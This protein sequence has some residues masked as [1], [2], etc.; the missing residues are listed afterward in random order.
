MIFEE[1]MKD[2]R[3]NIVKIS[4]KELADKA[5]TSFQNISSYER[6]RTSCTFDIGMSLLNALGVS[7]II[8]NN[9]I[10][11][12]DGN[13]MNIKMNNT[14][15]ERKDLEFIT[16][17]VETAY[18]LHKQTIQ[19]EEDIALKEYLQ[20]FD[21]LNNAGY[22]V[23]SS[24]LLDM[25]LWDADHY[26]A[27]ESLVTISKGDREIS[28]ISSGCVDIDFFLFEEFIK[29]IKEKYPLEGAFIEKV[30]LFE[31]LNNNKGSDIYNIFKHNG[32][33]LYIST[34][35]DDYEYIIE[36][37]LSSKDYFFE[38]VEEYDPKCL[39]ISDMLGIYDCSSSAYPYYVFTMPDGE[40]VIAEESFEGHSISEALNYAIAYFEHDYDRYVEIYNDED[41]RDELRIL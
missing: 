27:H 21:K 16:F 6:G 41:L 39:T 37:T 8:E 2:V 11:L 25:R 28:L 5:H 35:L 3:K 33:I 40:R 7:V 14:K 24:R 36:E 9:K 12:K 31:C 1:F 18:E 30:L 4:Q 17:N 23:F 10:F 32:N 22:E 34:L 38:V 29:D 15:Y 26:P 19:K 20:A 13:D